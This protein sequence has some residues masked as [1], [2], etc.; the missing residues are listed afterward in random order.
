MRF[1]GLLA[2]LTT[3]LGSALL[4][5]ATVPSCSS[6]ARSFLPCELSFDIQS[7]E[8]AGTPADL[9]NVEFRSP[10]HKTY[11][12]R[13]YLEGTL[14]VRFS[15]TEVGAWTYHVT[16]Q[17]ARY[18]DKEESFLVADSGL[19]GMVSVANLR[20]W[21]TTNKQ[22]HLW[23]AAGSP[24]LDMGQTEWESWLDARKKDGFTHIRGPLLTAAG[25]APPFNAAGQPSSA[26]FT[27]LDDRLVAAV[28]RGFALDLLLADQS[29]LHT[30][31]FKNFDLHEPV[32]RYL[33]T[34][35]GAFNVTWQG[36]EHFED[37]PDSRTLLK[38]LAVYLQKYDSFS[39]PRSTDARVSS[40]PLIP[41]GWM[42]FLV[43]ASPN[44]Q[45]GA[46]EHQ[47]TEQPEIHVIDTV[48]PDA[49]RHEL[50]NCTTNGQ[51]PS[52]S[53]ESLRN[54][55]N[56]KA[57]QIWQHVI[58]G[59]RHWELEPY[60]DVD[61][62]R[63]VGL[64]EVEY[65]AYAQNPGIVEISLPR[66]KYNPVWV[67]PATGEELELKDYKGEV[68][69]RSTPGNSHD[70]IL[71]VPRDGE[72]ASRLK[73]FYFESEDPPVQ[74]IESDASKAPFEVT[75]PQSVGINTALPTPYAVKT[76]RANRASRHMQ[77]AWWGEV[78]TSGQDARLLGLGSS[79]TFSVP[80]E[81][82]KQPGS[83]LSVRV[84]AINAVGKA[85]EIDKVYT[86]TP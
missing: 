67:N 83:T 48:E 81:L 51:Y 36:I 43:E 49:F 11:L 47:F 77:F 82:L 2:A 73:Y 1:K 23:L 71:Q 18:N 22:P 25:P 9:L 19:P 7:A 15:P 4:P 10:A 29:F 70:W 68:F 3:F 69:T 64:N 33:V 61:G 78:I 66:H 79:G 39:H 84:L 6:G 44:P 45:L 57:V 80:K 34:R 28:N 40:F 75:D 76:T 85:Y 24:F 72:K 74:E 38:D 31:F 26:Y 20:H 13:A 60:F 59:T 53:S 56:L 12:M 52:I 54:E 32:I 86:L 14:H 37:T 17:I 16:S 58:S 35:Y 62:A 55:A 65:L 8:A 63:A 21:R 46:V 5:A 27:A 41:D 42:N 50:W 30:G